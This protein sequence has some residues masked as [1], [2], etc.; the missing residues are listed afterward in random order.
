MD[1]LITL[2]LI[3]FGMLLGQLT[4]FF[5]RERRIHR[6]GPTQEQFARAVNIV[7]LFIIHHNRHNPE[8]KI[9]HIQIS[10]SGAQ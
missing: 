3:A 5:F 1:N 6:H 4:Y 10:E 7:T 2:V 9:V 8:A